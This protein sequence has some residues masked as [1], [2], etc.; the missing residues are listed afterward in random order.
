MLSALLLL[1]LLADKKSENNNDG[2][3]A[4]SDD[5]DAAGDERSVRLVVGGRRGRGDCGA[6]SSIER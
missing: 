1:L 6:N 3:D 5:S 4:N 2:V